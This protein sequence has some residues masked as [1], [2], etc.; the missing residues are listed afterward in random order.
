MKKREDWFLLLSLVL[1]FTFFIFMRGNEEIIPTIE[2]PLSIPASQFNIDDYFD[3]EAVTSAGVVTGIEFTPDGRMFYAEL[4]SGRVMSYKDGESTLFAN[5]PNHLI[6]SHEEGEAGLMSLTVHPDFENNPFVYVYVS[7]EGTNK[8]VRLQDVGGSGENLQVIFDGVPQAKIHNGGDLAFGSD[9]MLYLSTGDTTDI[10]DF[11]AKTNPAQFV[12]NLQGKIL[13]MK[14]DGSMPEDNPFPDTYTFAYGLRNP[15]GMA[16]HP[17]TNE[18]YV[19]D[20]GVDCCDEVNLVKAGQNYGWPYEMGWNSFLQEGPIYSWGDEDRPAPTG[21]DFYQGDLYMATWRTR[22][23]VRFILSEE[24]KVASAITY[25]VH[26]Q[27]LLEITGAHSGYTH[28]GAH[29]DKG[30]VDVKAGPDG[31]LY[32]SDTQHIFRMKPKSQ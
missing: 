30:F 29:P 11:D 18:L 25:T 26:G 21:M 12:D 20:N 13:R 8:I 32:F 5:I 4:N 9:N 31:Y 16:F 19:S 17:E 24:G 6:T 14:D 1:I 3:I 27:N 10:P 7:S 28:K 22:E 2:S 15:F 23:I